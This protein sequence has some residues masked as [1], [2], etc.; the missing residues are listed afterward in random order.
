MPRVGITVCVK[1]IVKSQ[2]YPILLRCIILAVDILTSILGVRVTASHRL[3][4]RISKCIS[5]FGGHQ[6]AYS[7][8]KFGTIASVGLLSPP[9]GGSPLLESLMM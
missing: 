6:S 4:H 5:H 3:W 2:I 1:I 7:Q 9:I 8:W